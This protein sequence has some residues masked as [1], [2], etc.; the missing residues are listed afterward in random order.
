M[1]AVIAAA[2]TTTTAVAAG[3]VQPVSNSTSLSGIIPAIQNFATG[4]AANASVV[5][6]TM[7][8]A[9]IDIGKA[10]V[11]FL[12]IAG[13]LLWFTRVNKHLGK[14]LVEGGIFIGIFIEF[15]VPFLM[16]IHF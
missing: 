1:S 11:V 16:S 6:L 7:D 3:A 8:N 15:V 10:A 9:A 13:V 14:E 2:S 4:F 12:V 5:T